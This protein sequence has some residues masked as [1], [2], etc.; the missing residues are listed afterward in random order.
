MRPVGS[1]G[2]IIGINRSIERRAMSRADILPERAILRIPGYAPRERPG[3]SQ[4]WAPPLRRTG[5]LHVRPSLQRGAPVILVTPGI[6]PD[7]PALARGTRVA[8]TDGR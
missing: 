6:A 7:Y 5:V 8:F 3:R 4:M 2:Q 1:E